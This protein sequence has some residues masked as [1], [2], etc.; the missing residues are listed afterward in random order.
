MKDI[1]SFYLAAKSSG[2]SADVSAYLEAV[3]QCLKEDPRSYLANVEYI[4]SSN[5]GVSTLRE[6]VETY[7]LPIVAYENVMTI[8]EDAIHRGEIERKDVSAHKEAKEYL[9][10][11]K[12]KYPNCFVMAEAISHD[13]PIDVL[14]EYVNTYYGKNGDNQNRNLMVGMMERFG[15]VAIPDLFVTASSKPKHDDAI[16]TMLE[17]F[18]AF[19]LLTS[20]TTKQWVSQLSS[21]IPVCERAQSALN[22]IKEGS[23]E[24]IVEKCIQRNN[25]IFREATIMGNDD[26]VLEYSPQ[27][28]MAIEDLISF[29]EYQMV[30]L[31]GDAQQKCYQEI[32]SLYEQLDGLITEGSNAKKTAIK[33]ITKRMLKLADDIFKAA[34]PIIKDS[35]EEFNQNYSFASGNKLT[36]PT[37]RVTYGNKKGPF[38]LGNTGLAGKVEKHIND[39]IDFDSEYLEKIFLF[40]TVEGRSE[41]SFTKKVAEDWWRMFKG[42]CRQ[43]LRQFD[44]KV[45]F[46]DA[47]NGTYYMHTFT[48]GMEVNRDYIVGDTDVGMFE[49][50]QELNEMIATDI[51]PMMAGAYKPVG[52]SRWLYNTSNKKNGHMPGYIANNHDLGYGEEDDDKK[53]KRSTSSDDDDDQ[54]HTLDDFR[55]PSAAPIEEPD[56]TGEPEDTSIPATGGSGDTGTASGVNNYYYYTYNNSLNQNRDSF[57]R[58]RTDDHSTH[59]RVN[60]DHSSHSSSVTDDHSMHTTN[61]DHSDGKRIDSNNNTTGSKH[62]DSDDDGEGDPEGQVTESARSGTVWQKECDAFDSMFNLDLNKLGD[63]KSPDKEIYITIGEKKMKFV[64]SLGNVPGKNEKLSAYTQV[65]SAVHQFN[66]NKSRICSDKIG[67]GRCILHYIKLR[68]KDFDTSMSIDAAIKKYGI[69]GKKIKFNLYGEIGL[70]FS[71]NL[72]GSEEFGV[73]IDNDLHCKDGDADIVMTEAVGDADDQRPKSDHPIKDT[74]MDIDRELGKKQ[75][76]AKKKVQ[77]VQ[78]VARAVTKP[79]KRTGMWI[80]KMLNQWRDANENNIKEKMADPHARSNLFS[81]IKTSIKYGSLA[82][83]G[84]LFNPVFLAISL[85]NKATKGSKEFRIRNEMI[86]ELKTE[87]AIIDEKIKDADSKGDNK[88]KYQLMR[89]K[90]ELNKKLLRVGGTKE[91]KKII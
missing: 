88:A 50:A 26:A 29:K 66:V 91:F 45:R 23:L 44:D 19:D 52:E 80:T 51:I 21:D 83:A 31:E 70:T 4:I 37:I 85:Y 15:E 74:M 49:S 61:D 38:N 39:I 47:F 30:C 48:F 42:K 89:F 73:L 62:D 8:L 76:A 9:E 22:T 65:P 2:S 54:D 67:I 86:G 81:A 59:S 87:I 82:K 1:K 33:Q 90:N 27:E 79:V 28:I 12:G 75:Q 14:K 56:E 6:F 69:K 71:C 41:G 60:D 16:C 57:N 72:N 58:T 36:I 17:G 20:A 46:G 10:S 68:D 25:T 35:I 24:N 32:M 77:D 40:I 11:F 63:V 55:R 53:P 5:A 13:R 18:N 3:N 43:V 64:S 34:R 78:N 7:G 84:L